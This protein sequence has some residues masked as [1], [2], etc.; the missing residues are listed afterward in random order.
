MD[1]EDI[2]LDILEPLS[3]NE[4]LISPYDDSMDRKTQFS[5]AFKAL[6]RSTQL[7]SRLLSLI[8]AY[9]LG[10]FLQNLG[11]KE[12]NKY[13]RKVTT[14]Y[15]VMVDYTFDIFEPRPLQ[16][17]TTRLVSVQHLKKLKREDVT[18]LR[19]ELILFAGAQN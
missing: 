15:L 16:L 4:Q 2:I 14:H 18:K 10:K 11:V 3:G 13:R 9:F 7:K 17:L 19:E 8:N 6:R 1:Y 12:R 5:I